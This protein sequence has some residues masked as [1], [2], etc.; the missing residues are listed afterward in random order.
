[1]G[2]YKFSLND[3]IKLAMT[4]EKGK[5]IGRAEYVETTQIYYVRYI[6]GDGRQCTEW[7]NGEALEKLAA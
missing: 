3:K 4:E 5:V 1:M 2:D 6:A 7:F